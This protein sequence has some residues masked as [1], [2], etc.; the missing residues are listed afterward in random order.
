MNIQHAIWQV[1]AQPTLLASS[2]PVSAPGAGVVVFHREPGDF[3][4]AGNP[5][6]DVVDIDT[7][8]TTAVLAQS[9]GVLYARAATRWATPGK[10]LA[11]IAG[12]TLQRKGKLL[13]A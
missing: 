8:A 12:S 3:V 13:G 11:K 7:G 1:G 4:E 5:V 10:R 6:A 9:S 2:E